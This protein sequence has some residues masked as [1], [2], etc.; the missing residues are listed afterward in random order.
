MIKRWKDISASGKNR[1]NHKSVSAN[2]ALHGRHRYILSAFA[3]RIASLAAE[4]ASPLGSTYEFPSGICHR[5][6]FLR[7]IA[8]P[9]S[10]ISLHFNYI[11]RPGVFQY[12]LLSSKPQFSLFS[13]PVQSKNPARAGFFCSFLYIF[14]PE[15]IFFIAEATAD[16]DLVRIGEEVADIFFGK[17]AKRG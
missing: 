16:F 3:D 9:L 17:A 12:V 7:F 1:R 2:I 15:F 6:R 5:L 11:P 10:E 8:F 4:Y 13:S 14:F